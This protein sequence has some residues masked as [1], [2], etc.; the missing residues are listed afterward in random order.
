MVRADSIDCAPLSFS[1]RLQWPRMTFMLEVMW[2]CVVA[3]FESD[4]KVLCLCNNIEGHCK[5]GRYDVG[6]VK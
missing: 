6:G 3:F 4:H 5:C 1:A 2:V